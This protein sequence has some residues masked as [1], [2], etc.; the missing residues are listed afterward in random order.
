MSETTHDKILE[1]SAKIFAEKGYNGTSMREIAETLNITKAALYY[2]FSG[3]EEI[4][5]V[6]ITNSLDKMTKAYESMAKSNDPIWNKLEAMIDGIFTF[7]QSQPHIFKLITMLI[8]RSFDRDIDKRIL[9]NFFR[10]Q[11]KSI[12]TIVQKGVEQGKIRDD[13][14]VNLLASGITG[15]IHHT[16]GPKI[17]NMQKINY[18]KEEQI[19]YLM[20]LLKGGFEKK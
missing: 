12:N 13:I 1:V 16:T 7:S 17:K 14:P 19:N 9:G 2:H 8:S 5:S 10:Q 11:Q 6:C 15:L 18:T 20:K 4:F 3:K